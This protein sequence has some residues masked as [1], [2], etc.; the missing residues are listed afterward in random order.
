MRL[1][2]GHEALHELEVGG[3][4][5]LDGVD[6]HERERRAR[7]KDAIEIGL[8]VAQHASIAVDHMRVLGKQLLHVGEHVQR[9]HVLQRGLLEAIDHHRLLDRYELEVV[10]V[11]DLEVGGARRRRGVG[12]FAVGVLRLHR[13]LRHQ[14][15]H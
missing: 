13:H 9:I 5:Y 6:R 14:G 1:L 12:L 10:L 2:E 4:V 7:E 11:H 8:Q 3:V 15:G